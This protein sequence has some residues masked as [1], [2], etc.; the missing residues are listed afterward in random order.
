M[1]FRVLENKVY[2]YISVTSISQQLGSAIVKGLPGMHAF[3]GCDSTS[4][5]AGHGKKKSMKLLIEDAEFRNFM[6]TLGD[7]F[8]LSQ[9]TLENGSKPYVLCTNL[10]YNEPTKSEMKGGIDQPKT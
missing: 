10:S 8:Q 9:S 2:R 5:F 7:T 3:S 4:Q 6:T 1:V